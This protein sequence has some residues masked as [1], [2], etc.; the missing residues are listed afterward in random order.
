M[1]LLKLKGHIES[2]VR[3]WDK[4]FK[5]GPSKICGIQRLKNLNWYGLLKHKYEAGFPILSV[6]G[7]S[8]DLSWFDW[9]LYSAEYSFCKT[10]HFWTA[11][12]HIS[13]FWFFLMYVLVLM[14]L[15]FRCFTHWLDCAVFYVGFL[16]WG[17]WVIICNIWFSYSTKWN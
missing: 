2:F 5:N 10:W 14:I 16:F 15:V 4:V 7:P 17:S 12:F 13:L 3:I 6:T 9:R 1:I 11:E 8:N